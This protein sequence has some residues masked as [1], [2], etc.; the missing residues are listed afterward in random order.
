MRCASIWRS[1]RSSSAAWRSVMSK[2]IPS[3]H[4]TPSRSIVLMPRSSTHRIPP[5]AWRIRYSRTNGR[6]ASIAAR[7]SWSTGSR[8]SGCVT[9]TIVRLAAPTKSDAGYPVMRSMSSLTRWTFQTSSS[10]AR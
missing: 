5:S 2:M 6:P 8:S 10:A 1:M 7:I 4:A 3:S 9:I